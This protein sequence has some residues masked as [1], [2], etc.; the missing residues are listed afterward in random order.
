MQADA[1]LDSLMQSGEPAR[2]HLRRRLELFL[3]VLAIFIGLSWIFIQ[4]ITAIFAWPH[5]WEFALEPGRNIHVVNLLVVLGA[6]LVAR[7][8][9]LSMAALERLDVV[10]TCAVSVLF[11]VDLATNPAQRRPELF[12]V[13]LLSNTLTLRAA[14]VPSSPRRSLGLGLFALLCAIGATFAMHGSGRPG[15]DVL[16]FPTVLMTSFL[17]SMAVVAT[18]I[19]SRVIYG[20][21]AR[22]SE[23]LR[24][25][26]YVLERKLGEGGMGIVYQ[27][28]H[29]ML[30]RPTAVKLISPEKT[31]PL[32]LARFEREVQLTASLAHPNTIAIYDYGRTAEGVF[33]YAMEYLDGL[34]LEALVELDGAQPPGRVAHILRQMCGALAEAHAVG[35]IHRDIKPANVVLCERGG[36]SDVVK[37][38]DFGLVKRRESAGEVKLSGDDV[39]V[40]TPLYMAP[41]AL[42][43]PDAIDGR[44]D[45][46]AVGAVGYYLLSGQHV[47][48]GAS[49]AAVLADHLHTAPPSIARRLGREVPEALEALLLRCLKKEPADRPAS[50][51][52]LLRGLDGCGLGWS[53][54]E[55]TAWWR[56]HAIARKRSA[57]SAGATPPGTLTVDIMRHA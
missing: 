48:G 36:E 52:E 14:L 19:V 16:W 51:A 56:G 50:A 23:A 29:A 22:A 55:A 45:L 49:V 32:L 24:L 2:R 33:Y 30:K 3:R 20:L 31:T 11:A 18:T 7:R 26:Q 44:A 5:F 12:L 37:V 39:L 1:G 8:R 41:E 53:Q 34:T 15:A 21:R 25:G 40:G 13:I 28:S 42:L 46:Y 17:M 47:F 57:P 27:A 43:T 38:L 10:A 35:L 9:D 6:W 4:A 54:A